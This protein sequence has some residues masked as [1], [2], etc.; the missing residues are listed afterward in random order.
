MNSDKWLWKLE[1]KFGKFAIHNLMNIII[2]GMAIVFV[3]DSIILPMSGKMQLSPFLV[4][5]RDAVAQGQIWRLISFVFLPPENDPLF[6]I[7][8]LYF[9]WMIGTVLENQW[10]SFKFNVFYIFG[11]IGAIVSGLITGTST[12]YF[13]NL[14]LFIAFAA[15]IP[16]F[17]IMIFFVLPVKIKYLAWIDAFYILYMF[18]IGNIAYKV[19]I[20]AALINLIIFFGSDFVKAVKYKGNHI[21]Y[22]IKNKR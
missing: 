20:I 2:M 8:I 1:R 11:I 4:F 21:M 3:M 7:F 19:A 13:M 16:N 14:S 22:K 15:M 9:Y 5:S 17:E 12:N 10:G 6:I 18:F